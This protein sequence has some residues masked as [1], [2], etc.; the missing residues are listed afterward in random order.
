MSGVRVA[1]S[2]PDDNYYNTLILGD[3]E[4]VIPLEVDL[5]NDPDDPDK[6]RLESEDGSY[7]VELTA[8]SEGV[9]QDGDNALNYYHFTG[10]IPGTYSVDVKVGDDW[11]T[12]IRGLEV[13]YKGAFVDG[14][15]FESTTDASQL[16]T[17]E[18]ETP[19]LFEDETED[20]GDC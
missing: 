10:V 11:H 14:Q 20:V 4:V 9:E 3:I 12:V 7:S 5:E 18:I 8:G 6:L 1:T 16:G 17:P 2:H 15:S 19:E 13:N